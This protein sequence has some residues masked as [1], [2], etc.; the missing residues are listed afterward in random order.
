M[1]SAYDAGQSFSEMQNLAAVPTT[2]YLSAI[3]GE[4]NLRSTADNTA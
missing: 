2:A 3:M 1:H 4:Q